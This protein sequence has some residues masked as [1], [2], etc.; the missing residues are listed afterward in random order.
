[1]GLLLSVV[2]DN[3]GRSIFRCHYF[4]H[5]ENQQLI[6]MYRLSLKFLT[7]KPQITVYMLAPKLQFTCKPQIYSLHTSPKITIYKLSPKLQFTCKPQITVYMLSPKLQFIHV[8]PK[9]TVY[10]CDPL[11]YSLHMWPPK[12]QFTCEPQNYSRLACRTIKYK[13]SYRRGLGAKM[14]RQ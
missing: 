13:H 5:T 10:T 3:S 11:N 9:I 6:H 14:Q 2:P 12:L 1:M 8:T 4:I 7:C